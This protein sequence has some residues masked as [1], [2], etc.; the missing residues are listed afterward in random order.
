MDDQGN[1]LKE[2]KN[3]DDGCPNIFY[4]AVTR[5]IEHL[6]VVKD[7]KMPPLH[8]LQNIEN[9]DYMIYMTQEMIENG[10]ETDPYDYQLSLEKKQK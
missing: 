5:A 7:I 4:V 10:I 2:K 8:F 9:N 6:I 1:I 3:V